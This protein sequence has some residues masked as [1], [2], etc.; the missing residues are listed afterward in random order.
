MSGIDG[1]LVNRRLAE[2]RQLVNE[3]KMLLNR[4]WTGFYPIHISGMQ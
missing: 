4:V 1:D 2:I 3:L